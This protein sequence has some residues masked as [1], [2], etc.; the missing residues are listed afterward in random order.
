MDE[1]ERRFIRDSFDR[2][3]DRRVDAF[4]HV[5][6]ASVVSLSGRRPCELGRF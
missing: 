4:G 3:V 2:Y 6:A 5:V 1:I